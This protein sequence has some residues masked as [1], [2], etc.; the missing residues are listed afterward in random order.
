MMDKDIYRLLNN[1][2]SE[3]PQQQPFTDSEVNHYMEDL[4]QVAVI[5]LT[6]A[7]LCYRSKNVIHADRTRIQ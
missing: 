7:Y 4:N 1:T 6:K 2:N 5:A 3:I